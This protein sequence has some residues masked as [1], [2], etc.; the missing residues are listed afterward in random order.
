MSFL[1]AKSLKAD[2]TFAL[3]LALVACLAPVT[4]D[5]YLASMPD[6]GKQLDASYASVQ[7]TLTVFLLAQGAG[8]I[9]FGPVID[10]FGRRIPLLIGIGAF[11]A[12]SIWSGVAG[13]INALLVSRF[14][15]GLSGALLLV[16]AF[17][18]VRDVA[19]GTKAARL[20]AILLT[21]EGLAPVFAPIAGGYIGAHFGWRAVMFASAA[22]GIIGLVN[23]FFNL[24]ESLPADKRLPLQPSTIAR[25]Y[26]SI[27]K[28]SNFLLPTLALSGVFFF[29]F[30]YIG[31]G[32]YLYQTIY[33]LTPDTFGIVFGV[34]GGTVML[35][36]I[37]SSRM[38]KKQMVSSVAIKGVLFMIAG[39][40]IA[41]VSSM[42][43]GIYGI[44]PGFM[45][46][47][48]GLGMAEPTLVSLTMA[49][50][51]TALGFTAALMG[52]LH[53]IL[54]SAATPITGVL[55]PM[56]KEYWFIFL[57]AAACVTLAITL[58]TRKR[59]R[60]AGGLEDVNA[61]DF[62]KAAKVSAH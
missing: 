18:S 59:L 60:R 10:R 31:G 5:M 49:S 21:I 27:F 37:A 7:L 32:A 23:S 51:K 3:S 8:Q 34:T 58:L 20:F 19:E 47:L 39:T 33:G 50:Q 11:I 17:S 9:F 4:T 43:I 46:A 35:G 41:L 12:G 57:F 13:S 42:T 15:Q 22:L 36:A 44:V 16:T 40:L 62:G 25:T 38:I 61:P 30:A 26:W 24:P 55:L 2:A 53:L 56:N 48:F 45:V 52:A 6:I 1:K 29:L 54:S 14:V 28:D